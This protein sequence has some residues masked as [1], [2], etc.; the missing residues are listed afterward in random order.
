[1]FLSSPSALSS[2]HAM[3]RGL[4]PDPLVGFIARRSS[5]FDEALAPEITFSATRTMFDVDLKQR[6]NPTS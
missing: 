5:S 6:R 1:M 2:A 4:G 3:T